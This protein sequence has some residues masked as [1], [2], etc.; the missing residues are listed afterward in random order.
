M[1][2]GVWSIVQQLSTNREIGPVPRNSYATRP[3][4]SPVDY[5]E[6]QSRFLWLFGTGTQQSVICQAFI[7]S[8]QVESIVRRVSLGSGSLFAPLK[9]F[10][11]AQWHAH[12]NGNPP[13]RCIKCDTPCPNL[14]PALPVPFLVVN[15]WRGCSPA[16]QLEVGLRGAICMSA[17]SNHGR[18]DE[19]RTDAVHVQG[20]DCMPH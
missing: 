7:S 11:R 10:P 18:R 6:R 4:F 20:A 19:G 1:M 8:F 9:R 17:G 2:S 13:R 12:R 14:C 3:P 5:L 16:I 15:T